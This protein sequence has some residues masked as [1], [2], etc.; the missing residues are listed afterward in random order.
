[1]VKKRD[2]DDWIFKHPA[3]FADIDRIVEEIIRNL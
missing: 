2:F 1:M 3:E